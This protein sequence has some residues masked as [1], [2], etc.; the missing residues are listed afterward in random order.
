MVIPHV[1]PPRR[2]TTPPRCHAAA[3][4]IQHNFALIFGHQ[5]N[6]NLNLSLWPQQVLGGPSFAQRTQRTGPPAI[7]APQSMQLRTVPIPSM[8]LLTLIILFLTDRHAAAALH[9]RRHALRS[10]PSPYPEAE[11]GS[12][13]LSLDQLLTS[14]RVFFAE[15]HCGR[16]VIPVFITNWLITLKIIANFH[17]C[18]S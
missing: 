12:Y 10:A 7:N 13:I 17:C 14:R 15:P 3:A 8:Y 1:L 6:R 16:D 2:I 18:S 5:R 11:Q 4:F 9:R